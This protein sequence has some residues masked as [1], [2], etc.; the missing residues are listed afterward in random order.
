MK[1]VVLLLL[2]VMFSGSVMAGAGPAPNSADGVADGSGLVSVPS[3][4]GQS[5]DPAGPNPLAG[6]GVSDG[7]I[8]DSPNGPKR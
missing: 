8:V 5:A 4:A 2:L 7:S 6:D 3:D 1:R